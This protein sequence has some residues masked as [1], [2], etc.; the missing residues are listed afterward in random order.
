MKPTPNRECYLEILRHMTPE[1]K[2]PM[3]VEMPQF[4]EIWC[5]K[6]VRMTNSSKP[7]KKSGTSP[8]VA[9]WQTLRT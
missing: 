2:A 5:G 8:G 4:A 1:Q 9:K 3:D 7:R 6:D